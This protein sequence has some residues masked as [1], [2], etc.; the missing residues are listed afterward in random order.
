VTKKEEAAHGRVQP[1]I[2]SG[3]K[4]GFESVDF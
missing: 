1:L 3:G 2:K 4:G